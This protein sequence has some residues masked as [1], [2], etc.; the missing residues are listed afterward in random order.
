MCTSSAAKREGQRLLG[1]VERDH[2]PCAHIVRSD[3]G[4][5]DF[6]VLVIDARAEFADVFIAMVGMPVPSRRT[7][8]LFWFE[9][10]D[11]LGHLSR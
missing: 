11:E 1:E 8:G 5:F 7:Q 10:G 3:D 2:R 9:S 4:D 6:H